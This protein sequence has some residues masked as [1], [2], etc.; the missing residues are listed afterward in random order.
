MEILSFL[1]LYLAVGLIVG[2]WAVPALCDPVDP[3]SVVGVVTFAV[4]ALWP[5]GLVI[6][7]FYGLGRLYRRR[8]R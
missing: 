5:F 7:F 6:W 4:V 2:W 3:D 1:V 8:I